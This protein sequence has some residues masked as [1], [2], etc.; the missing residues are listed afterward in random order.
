MALC[1]CGAIMV[2]LPGGWTCLHCDR[3]SCPG[4]DTYCRQIAAHNDR[5]E[6]QAQAIDAIAELLA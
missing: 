1:A 4:R 2:P 3:P 5:H 6:V